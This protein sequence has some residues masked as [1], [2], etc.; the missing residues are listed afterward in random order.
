[1]VRGVRFTISITS[2]TIYVCFCPLSALRIFIAPHP[3]NPDSSPRMGGPDCVYK[4]YRPGARTKSL[5]SSTI[6]W[7]LINSTS[8]K[9]RKVQRRAKT[10]NRRSGRAPSISSAP[11]REDRARSSS[12]QEHSARPRSSKIEH[13]RGVAACSFARC[14]QHAADGAKAIAQRCRWH[15]SAS[16]SLR[17]ETASKSETLAETGVLLRA[18]SRSQ[19]HSSYLRLTRLL[20][21]MRIDT[22][23]ARQ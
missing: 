18:Q 12:S 4:K 7:R 1:M 13:T 16:C 6:S 8:A 21:W 10:P 9:S 17:I 19:R 14:Q 11:H 20:D 23:V 2:I 5:S 22:A 3:P 15:Q